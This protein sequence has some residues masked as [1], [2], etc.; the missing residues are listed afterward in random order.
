MSAEPGDEVYFHHDGVPK[1]G[2]VICSGKHGCTVDHEGTQH[3]IKWEY[4]R[5]HK[6]RTPQ[7]YRV[8]HNGEDG[9]IV[10][11]QH[12]KRKLL[13]IPPEARGE[14]HVLEQKNRPK[15]A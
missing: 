14:R 8:L 2:K 6:S 9:V 3:K 13:S 7:Q 1:V 10:E 5:G 12:G 11:N 4:L 15:S